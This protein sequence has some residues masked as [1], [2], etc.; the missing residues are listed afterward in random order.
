L[1]ASPRA[2]SEEL[3]PPAP[4]AAPPPPPPP[5]PLPP[6]PPP[7]PI[8]IPDATRATSEKVDFHIERFERAIAQSTN[9]ARRAELEANLK[10]WRAA[11]A[12]RNALLG[13]GE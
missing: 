12:S 5:P 1:S 8:V 7:P 3:E 11:K 9:P 10:F 2:P 4:A 13:A 6:P